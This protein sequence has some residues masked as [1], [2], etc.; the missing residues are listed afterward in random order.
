MAINNYFTENQLKEIKKEFLFYIK[1][2]YDFPIS[3][4]TICTWLNKMNIYEN[5]KNNENYRKYFYNNYLNKLSKDPG[6]DFTINI[7][8]GIELPLFSTHGFEALCYLL[9]TN[10]T[11]YLEKCFREVKKDY[12]NSFSQER[13]KLVH[14]YL[15]SKYELEN[16]I[17]R[18]KISEDELLKTKAKN[19]NLKDL[20]NNV[21]R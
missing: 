5:Y 7:Y 8:N 6:C 18:V 12:W 2:D 20:K 16:L 14:E 19:R 21:F 13:K 3:L 17:N 9:N 10:R 15:T 11:K 1:N 4:Q